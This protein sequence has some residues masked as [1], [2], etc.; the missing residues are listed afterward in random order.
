[1]TALLLAAGFNRARTSRCAERT[2]QLKQFRAS[3]SFLLDYDSQHEEG[4][5]PAREV[6]E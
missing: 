2:R 5:L 3:N 1:M 4:V 6:N